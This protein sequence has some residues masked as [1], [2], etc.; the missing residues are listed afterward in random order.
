MPVG[1]AETTGPHGLRVDFRLRAQHALHELRGRHFQ[2]QHQNLSVQ[3]HTDMLRDVQGEGRLSHARSAGDDHEVGGL[4]ARRLQIEL[5]EARGHAGHVLLRSEEHTSE[6]QSLR[7]L[8]FRLLLPPCSAL[9]PYTTLFRSDISRLS[10]RTFPCNATPTCCAMF[11]AKAVFPMLGRPAM[12][13]KSAG[14]RPDV[15]RSS[16]SKPVAT[17]VT[18]SLRS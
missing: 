15:S 11:K 18:C 16:F 10:T 9:F 8:V 13:T 2:T 1:S 3:R 14:C 17:P 7:H 12:I 6:L 4:Q 5:L